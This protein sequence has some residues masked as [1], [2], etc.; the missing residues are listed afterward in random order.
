MTK[1]TVFVFPVPVPVAKGD[2]TLMESSSMAA[3]EQA[4]EHRM[5]LAADSAQGQR[6]SSYLYAQDSRYASQRRVD[7]LSQKEALAI[8]TAS[9][10]KVALAGMQGKQVVMQPPVIIGPTDAAK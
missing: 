1:G 9:A 4:W 7:D 2:Q 5:V 6:E 3:H 10:D 8:Q